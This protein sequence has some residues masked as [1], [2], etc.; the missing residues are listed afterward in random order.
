VKLALRQQL[1]PE[2]VL[3]A[4]TQLVTEVVSLVRQQLVQVVELQVQRRLRQRF[5]L[6]QDALP[7]QLLYQ[8]QHQLLEVFRQLV[9][10]F[11]C[12]LCQLKLLVVLHR[13]L[14][15]LQHF[16]TNV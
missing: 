16:L 4:R 14:L 9:K 10:E 1:V 5:Q 3:L 8:L 13:L 7:L 2:V 11:Q 12:Q 15:S 6:I